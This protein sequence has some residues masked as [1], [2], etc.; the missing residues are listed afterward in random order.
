MSV[1]QICNNFCQSTDSLHFEHTKNFKEVCQVII[2][3]VGKPFIKW[4]GRKHVDYENFTQ[5]V[6]SGYQ[7]QVMN[8]VSGSNVNITCKEVE[9]DIQDKDPKGNLI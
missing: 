3:E 4:K 7:T 8:F 2:V 1:G 6:I 5:N 9:Q